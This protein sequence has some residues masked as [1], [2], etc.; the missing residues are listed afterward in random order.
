MENFTN[1]FLLSMPHLK[2][3]IFSESLIY[4]CNHNS[5]GA[6]GI[7]INKLISEKNIYNI[8][9]ETKLEQLK[10]KLKIYFGGPVDIKT[11][12]FLHD[13]KYEI[14]GTMKI[15]KSISLSSNIKIINDIKNGHGPDKFKFA[16]G[17][18][19]WDNGQLEKE[20]ENGDWLL[21]P[22]N[23]DLIFNTPSSEILKKLNSTMNIDI[24]NFSGGI[25]GL[26]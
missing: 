9:K 21:I 17:Y 16:L 18:A 13:Q 23:D 11:G 7:I 19:G 5:S 10:P 24:N 4:I 2:D 14:E 25:S 26:S 12:M 15:S 6:M 22:S 20:I 1:N 3:S 8:L